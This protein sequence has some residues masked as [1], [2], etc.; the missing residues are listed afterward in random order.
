MEHWDGAQTEMLRLL[1]L[2]RKNKLTFIRITVYDKKPHIQVAY[3]NSKKRGGKKVN[4]SI[5][6]TDDFTIVA[7]IDYP[8]DSS[9][10]DL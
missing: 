8:E 2:E 5:F 4:N 9:I 1:L 6:N 7:K 10:H 3:S